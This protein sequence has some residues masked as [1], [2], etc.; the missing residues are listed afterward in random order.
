MADNREK[1]YPDSSVEIS[2]ITAKY[3]EFFMNLLTLGR[4]G[5]FISRVIRE[6]K[7]KPDD[8]ILD[9]GAGNGYNA[10]KMVRYL[11]DEG[12]LIGLDIGDDMIETF[13]K[14]CSGHSNVSVI[15]RRIDIP[16]EDEFKEKFDKVFISFVIHG[17]PHESRLQVLKNAA[18]AL[19]EG[20]EFFI[21]DYNEFEPEKLPFYKRVA[22]QFIEC[23]YAFDYVRRD[24]KRLLE[25][26]GFGNFEE[27]I[28]FL[29]MVR[30]L[31]AVKK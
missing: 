6:M 21:L 7:I 8:K 17:L 9:L 29:G 23:P 4:Y 19:K 30:L 12:Q 18:F 20:G 10:C 5:G 22:F 15:K 28:Y 1:L 16:F 13:R 27:K 11:S 25:E 31:K 14:K 3:Y 2:G 24:W 26:A